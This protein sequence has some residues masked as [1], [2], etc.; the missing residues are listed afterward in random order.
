M[1]AQFEPRHVETNGFEV[2]AAVAGSGPLAILVHGWPE[3]WY[4]WRHQIGPSA[5]ASVATDLAPLLDQRLPDLCHQASVHHGQGAP[6]RALGARACPRGR[7]ET[8]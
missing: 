4:S 1:H 2:R 5:E 8:A 7:R 6:R 3:L